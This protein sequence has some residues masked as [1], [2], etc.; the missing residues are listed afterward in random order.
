MAIARS[1]SELSH[2]SSRNEFGDAY[3]VD[4][5]RKSLAK[6]ALLSPFRQGL[7]TLCSMLVGFPLLGDLQLVCF[8]LTPVMGIRY[9]IPPPLLMSVTSRGLDSSKSEFYLRSIITTLG[10]AMMFVLHNIYHPHYNHIITH[11][12]TS[13]LVPYTAFKIKRLKDFDEVISIFRRG[14]SEFPNNPYVMAAYAS[15]LGKLLNDHEHSTRVATKIDILRVYADTQFQIYMILE[16]EQKDKELFFL[17][18]QT[19]VDMATLNEYSHIIIDTKLNHYFSMLHSRNLW[20]AGY[21]LGKVEHL[22]EQLQI[23]INRA[24]DGYNKLIAR[25]GSKEESREK[26]NKRLRSKLL[27]RN[28]SDIK[29]LLTATT[30]QKARLSNDRATFTATQSLIYS[31]MA[32]LKKMAQELFADPYSSIRVN[33][34]SAFTDTWVQFQLTFYPELPNVAVSVNG[35]LLDAMVAIAN[36]G[37]A[38]SGVSFDDFRMPEISVNSDFRLIA[39]N[40]FSMQATYNQFR[41][42]FFDKE[43]SWA[44][45]A[46]IVI[47]CL[48]GAHIAVFAIFI[49]ILDV[50]LVQRFRK[51]QNEMLE[52]FRVLPSAIKN[53]KLT[54]LEQAQQDD[55]LELDQ[56]YSNRTGLASGEFKHRSF[57]NEYIAYTAAT[58][59]LAAAFAYLNILNVNY[60]I[61]MIGSVVQMSD[62]EIRTLRT[63]NLVQ[64]LAWNDTMTWS[65][66]AEIRS[67][68]VNEV[69][70]A[71]QTYKDFMFGNPS[72]KPASPSA[73]TYLGPE[74]L[75]GGITSCLAIDPLVCDMRVYD[76]SI[77]YTPALLNYGIVHLQDS[78]I[79]IF[80]DIAKSAETGPFAPPAGTLALLDK[81]LE[82]DLFDGWALR[83]QAISNGLETNLHSAIVVNDW[84]LAA[85]ILTIFVGQFIVFTRMINYFQVSAWHPDLRRRR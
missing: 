20:A 70:L 43:Q 82:P 47:L 1:A 25:K 61:R 85:E 46:V 72:R 57:R 49:L 75:S 51:K 71:S 24:E 19:D 81:V 26:E 52:V 65:S 12:Q 74:D 62:L 37:M 9:K 14:L 17:D 2:A 28:R 4:S 53:E 7:Y 32:D 10:A 38:L 42:A 29:R 48:T 64:E 36:S 60:L 30:L 35:T 15:Y 80:K 58:I 41:N 78:L 33:G 39:D 68:I 44:M 11:T 13:L 67:N 73:D 21:S 22:A 23:C 6:Q 84:I 5:A 31:E 40:W 69:A 8:Y 79:N 66:D 34:Y 77:G 18:L 16:T 76:S 59:A 3:Q 50:V 45:T 56:N 55:I 63:I 83:R 27:K 54:A